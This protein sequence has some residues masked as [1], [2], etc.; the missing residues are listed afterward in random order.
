[1][2]SIEDFAGKRAFTI[3]DSSGYCI[4]AIVT[5]TAASKTDPTKA[6][7]PNSFPQG[8][9]NSNPPLVEPT[10]PNSEAASAPYPDIDVGVVVDIKGRL[11]QFRG[12]PQVKVEKMSHLR[13]TA[14]EVLLW[15]KRA[16]FRREVLDV[17]WTLRE[18]DIRRCRKEAEK[19]EASIMSKQQRIQAAVERLALRHPGR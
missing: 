13:S 18:R 15:E 11:C 3:D 2:V 6:S 10:G 19:Y 7:D 12:E 4:E 8:H 5:Y 1:M 17:V 14:Q 16:K 9:A